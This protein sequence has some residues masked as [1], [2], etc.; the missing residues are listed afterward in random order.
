MPYNQYEREMLT[1][2]HHAFERLVIAAQQHVGPSFGQEVLHI[3]GELERISNELR[4]EE[5][6]R[7][8][9]GRGPLSEL[10]VKMGVAKQYGPNLLEKVP[11]QD[12]ATLK[13]VHALVKEFFHP[14]VTHLGE[15]GEFKPSLDDLRELPVEVSDLKQGVYRVKSR[16]WNRG[17]RLAICV[18]VVG[19]NYGFIVISLPERQGDSVVVRALNYLESEKEWVDH[20]HYGVVSKGALRTAFVTLM[21]KLG[22]K[23]P[24]P[25]QRVE[26]LVQVKR[27]MAKKEVVRDSLRFEGYEIT[28][29]KDEKDKEQFRIT[30]RLGDSV[31]EYK[32]MDLPTVKQKQFFELITD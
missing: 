17:D 6:L 27:Y 31:T 9:R 21:R 1:N 23:L 15:G 19:V 32:W 28:L 24:D 13:D 4:D 2:Y 25:I 12:K 16:T 11:D 29:Y 30:K 22:Y 7:K 5:T 8:I 18:Q 10:K 20:Q 3:S 26:F 14:T